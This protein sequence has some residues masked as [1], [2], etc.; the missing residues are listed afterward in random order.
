[1]AYSDFNIRQVQ[2]VFHLKIEERMGI[3]SEID[4]I[5]ISDYFITTLEENLPLAVSINTEKAR[6]ELIISDVLIEVRKHFDRKI[7]FFSGI[8]FTVDKDKDLTGYCDFLISLSPEQLF[9]KSPVVAVVEAK[10]ENI[11]S[12]LGQCIAEMVA[13]RLFNEREGNEIPFT[14]GAVTSG[15]AWKFLKLVDNKVYLDLSDYSIETSPAQI[16]GILSHMV[17][18]K[19]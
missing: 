7:S 14:Y 17:E 3:F 12:G 6:S 15:V 10:N 19:A 8:E 4:E 16:I 5:P 13:V 11:M 9:V 2:Q 1:M 18:Q